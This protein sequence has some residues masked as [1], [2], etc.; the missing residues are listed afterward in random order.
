MIKISAINIRLLAMTA[1]MTVSHFLNDFVL[2]NEETII[3]L[4]AE[5]A[6]S[7][8]WIINYDQDFGCKFIFVSCSKRCVC[9]CVFV[10]N[11]IC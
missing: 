8:L 11:A 5:R 3:V 7:A 1:P 9:V 4:H 10:F 2:W 6:Y